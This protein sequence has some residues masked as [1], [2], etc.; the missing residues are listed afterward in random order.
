MIDT[1]CVCG[2]WKIREEKRYCFIGASYSTSYDVR[3]D[4]YDRRDVCSRGL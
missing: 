3:T 2:M 4:D 1:K